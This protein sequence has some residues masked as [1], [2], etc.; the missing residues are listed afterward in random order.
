MSPIDSFLELLLAPVGARVLNPWTQVDVG[1]D[2][3][4]NA[5]AERLQRLRAHLNVKAKLLLVGEAPG[6][7][8][9]HV[10]GIAFTS[11]RLLLAGSI[12]RVEVWQRLSTRALPWSEPSAT[13]VWGTLHELAIAEHTLLWNAFPWHPHN[14]GQLQTNRTPTPA[15]RRLGV[16]VLQALLRAQPKAR[17]LAVGRTAAASLQEMGLE[18]PALRHPSMGGAAQFRA[19]LRET[20]SR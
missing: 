4:D 8:G 11:E 12:P 2:V 7:Q 19:Q 6:Y 15:E 18:V 5:A 13:T 20:V 10:S 17:V 14:E 9:C 3:H 16:P 1:T